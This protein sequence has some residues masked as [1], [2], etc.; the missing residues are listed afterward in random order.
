MAFVWTLVSK[1]ASAAGTDWAPYF[2][3]HAGKIS[4]EFLIGSLAVHVL[5]GTPFLFDTFG[6]LKEYFSDGNGQSSGL[7]FLFGYDTES[8]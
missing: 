6:P 5:F 1:R 4:L 8:W 3:A 2:Y 7:K